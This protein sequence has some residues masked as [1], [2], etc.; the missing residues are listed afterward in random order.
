MA[1][2]HLSPR[3]DVETFSLISRAEAMR[4]EHAQFVPSVN[5][6]SRNV[7]DAVG[8]VLIEPYAEGRPNARYYPGQEVN[9]DVERLAMARARNL[10]DSDVV[11]VQPHSGAVANFAAYTG[12]VG[13][14]TLR[15]RRGRIMG[16]SLAAGGHLSHGADVSATSVFFDSIPYGLDQDGKIDFEAMLER[17]KQ[18]KPDIIVAGTTAYS[19]FLEWDKFRFVADQVGA[20]LHADISHI[21]GL[22]AGRVHPSPSEWVDTWMTT[23][24]K[25]LR[26]ARG[27]MIGITERGKLKDPK[28]VSRINSAVFPMLQ[29]GPHMHSI[30]GIAVTLFEASQPEFRDYAG[31]VVETAKVLSDELQKRGI[32]I[33]TGGTDN[34]L[35]LADL[36]TRGISGK[37]VS[38][39]LERVYI[40]ANSNSVPSDP[41]PFT[42]PAGVRLG[43][44]AAASRNLGHE[45]MVQF[46]DFIGRVVDGLEESK[47]T[48]GLSDEDEID[49]DKRQGIIEQ[50][51]FLGEIREGVRDITG[52]FPIP[53]HYMYDAT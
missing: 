41:N 8:S 29:G 37:T 28:L 39:A 14:D 36:T 3:V 11:N 45:E 24:H 7:R 50:V 6:P 4:A 53:D 17:A 33:V 38:Q 21:A 43:T 51:V 20:H 27:A 9:D 35:L 34:H 12:I 47:R 2:E 25:S 40:L 48:L 31:R 22:I 26:G 42:R 19:R 18:T 5:Y 23:T 30:A 32:P 10:F 13:K 44:P 16:L 15:Q 1:G 49:K 52:R 46:A